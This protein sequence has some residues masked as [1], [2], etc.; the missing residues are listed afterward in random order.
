MLTFKHL[1]IIDEVEAEVEQPPAPPPQRIVVK[2][3]TVP[4]KMIQ[5]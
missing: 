3:N 4:N 1:F 2:H 5:Q